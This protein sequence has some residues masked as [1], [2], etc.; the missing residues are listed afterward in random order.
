MCKKI[1]N[2]DP[3]YGGVYTLSYIYTIPASQ[4]YSQAIPHHSLIYH[5][6]IDHNIRLGLMTWII[7]K[8]IYFSHFYYTDI[9]IDELCLHIYERYISLKIVFL[10]WFR[11]M[12]DTDGQGVQW[13]LSLSHCYLAGSEREGIP[14]KW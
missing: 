9:S 2:I 4:T 5:V 13:V 11:Y 8:W 10:Y 6:V 1:S 14:N 3:I 12:P 7:K